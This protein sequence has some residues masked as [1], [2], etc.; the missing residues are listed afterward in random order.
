MSIE[1]PLNVHYG[2]DKRMQTTLINANCLDVLYSLNLDYNKC[3]IVSDPPFNVGY[4]YNSYNDRLSEKDY[5]DLL[6]QV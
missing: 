5:M 4:H 2:K 1:C 3:V 6:K